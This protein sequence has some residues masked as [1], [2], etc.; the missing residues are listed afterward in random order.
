MPAKRNHLEEEN[1][2]DREIAF[3]RIIF[4]WVLVLVILFWI[5]STP[6][7]TESSSVQF[8]IRGSLGG[9]DASTQRDG[10]C[11]EVIRTSQ[12]MAQ[13]FNAS[14]AM[15]WTDPKQVALWWGPKGFTATIE[16]GEP[17]P[18]FEMMATFAEE[19][20]TPLAMRM[21]FVSAE[22]RDQNVRE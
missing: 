8:L 12:T 11:A 21:V 3:T 15:V 2:A 22:G 6:S 18:Q 10:E 4:A 20:K 9:G 13:D 19:G 16:R 7:A 5:T 1:A 14:H 17:A